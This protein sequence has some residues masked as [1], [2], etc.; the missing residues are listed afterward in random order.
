[1]AGGTYRKREHYGV[2]GAGGLTG[3]LAGG[4][5][6]FTTTMNQRVSKWDGGMESGRWEH[7]SQK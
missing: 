6:I 2:K 7:K 1:M 3:G 5:L 4:Q